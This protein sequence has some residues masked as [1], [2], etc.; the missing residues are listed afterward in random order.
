VGNYLGAVGIRTKM[1]TMERAAYLPARREKKL[2]GLIL[3][4]VGGVWQR[5]HAH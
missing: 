1:R 5:R 4:G 3:T 2:K